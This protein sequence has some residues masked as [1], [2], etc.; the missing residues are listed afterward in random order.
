MLANNWKKKSKHVYG[1]EL[2][3]HQLAGDL[4]HVLVSSGFT[5]EEM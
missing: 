2:K 3:S 4:R 1:L 5:Y